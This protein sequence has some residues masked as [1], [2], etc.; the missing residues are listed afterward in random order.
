MTTI[1]EMACQEL[2]ERV[3]EYLDTALSDTDRA[4]FEDHIGECP[5]CFEVLEQFRAVVQLT[6]ALAP[7]LVAEID[8]ATRDS[9]VDAFRARHNQRT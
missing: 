6:G 3:T 5:G 9:L 7:E 4:R 1:H 2:V 8:P